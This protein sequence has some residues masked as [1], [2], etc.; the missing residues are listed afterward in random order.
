MRSC[1]FLFL[2]SFLSFGLQAQDMLEAYQRAE[3]FMAGNVSKIVYN[4]NVIPHFLPNSS[5]FWYVNESESGKEYYLVD[6][7]K[8]TN[9]P[10][11]NHKMLAKKLAEKSGKET[12]SYDLDLKY[13]AF[14]EDEQ[15][16]TF[17]F[18]DKKWKYLL[19]KKNLE[20]EEESN[21]KKTKLESP[22][23]KWI[24]FIKDFNIWLKRT[25]TGDTIQLS[26]DGIEKY[27]YGASLS[28]YHIK[29]ESTG[30][31]DDPYIEVYWSP[32]SE[33]LI[34][35]R[36]DRRN[37]E[38]LYLFEST[39][40]EG[41]RSNVYSY[42][43]PLAGDSLLTTV[44]YVMFDI[45][46]RQQINLNITPN[47]TFLNNA[48]EWLP[49]SM[50]A[51]VI[52][53]SRGYKS[54]KLVEI[55]GRTGEVKMLFNE[56]SETYVDP[57]NHSFF[58]LEEVGDILWTSER[59]GWNHIYLYDLETGTYV[60][61]ITSGEFVVNQ[62]KS[63]NQQKNVIY[64]TA[65]GHEKDDPY[66]LYLYATDFDGNYIRRISR[67]T[68][69]HGIYKS[70]DKN[71]FVDVFSRPDLPPEV[72]VFRSKD[73][74]K[75][76]NVAKANHQNLVELGWTTPETFKLKARDDTTD[77][78]GI[79]YKPSNFD[80]SK[81]YPVIDATYSG[82]HTIKTP[83]SFRRAILNDEQTIAELGFIVITVD[84]LGTAFR[85]KAFHDYSY[86]NLGDI[87]CEDHVKAIKELAAKYRYMD[88]TRVGIYGTSAG[89]YD[90]VRAMI[91]RPDFY[92]V[93]VSAAGNH[94]HRIAK[95][96]LPELYMGFPAGKHYDE[97]SNILNA[98][99]IKGKLLLVHGN[100]DNNVNPSGTLRLADELIKANKDFEFFITPGDD[101]SELYDNKYF[102][103]RRWDFF[104]RHLLNKEPP[105]EYN[106]KKESIH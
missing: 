90:A 54:R 102:I 23:K 36:Y 49:S 85:S 26:F 50:K 66:N 35:P 74:E 22:D 73:G 33:K 14:S 76:M 19:T 82:P 27:D 71:Y 4:E 92:K 8:K 37:A 47:A 79:I 29:N 11:F 12:D 88:T 31:K 42:E 43:R 62:I 45:D 52:K 2:I 105:S 53:Y 1:R 67:Q 89:G 30:G 25:E 32:N 83:K 84:G 60:K 65:L 77:I 13:L 68:G 80:P 69:F 61:Q 72:N 98:N 41:F 34:V 86:K 95:A 17:Q 44:E 15:E 7:E 93:A 63:V 46:S 24:A 75:I 38:N 57:L 91:L 28:W 58:L 99:K 20:I 9:K 87:G 81:K 94:D 40:E 106:I 48:V 3:Q 96:W 6:P 21:S 64:F 18:D 55:D 5:K 16:I 97:Q 51:F 78:Y 103:R 56:F 70:T 39:P 104:V 59:S 10:A 101:H 100:M